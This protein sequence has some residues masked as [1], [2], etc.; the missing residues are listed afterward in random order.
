MIQH[1]AVVTGGSIH[2]SRGRRALAAIA[3]PGLHYCPGSNDEAPATRGKLIYNCS[4][5]FPRLNPA[6]LIDQIHDLPLGHIPTHHLTQQ[7]PNLGIIIRLY[8]LQ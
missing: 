5:L 6:L 8:G 3:R 4:R 2:T 1:V 7:H